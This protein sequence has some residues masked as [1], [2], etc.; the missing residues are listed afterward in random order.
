MC[1]KGNGIHFRFSALQPGNVKGGDNLSTARSET[2]F[3]GSLGSEEDKKKR[4]HSDLAVIPF[5]FHSDNTGIL[6]PFFF[7]FLLFF[8]IR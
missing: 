2:V 5:R 4:P 7:L 6:G 1:P 3:R 8:S